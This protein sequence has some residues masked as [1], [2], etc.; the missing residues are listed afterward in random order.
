MNKVFI[1]CE[2]GVTNYGNLELAKKQIDA[3]VEAGADA[4]KF[5]AWKTE[6]LVSKKVAARLENELGYNWFDRLKYK[7]LS[8]DILRELQQYAQ[9]KE[10]EFFATPHDNESLDFVAR[11]LNVP[12]IKIGSGEA[13]NYEFLKRAGSYSKPI[14]ISFGMHNDNEIKKAVETLKNSGAGDIAIFHCTTKYPTP[15][16]EIDLPRISHL[17]NITGLSVGFSDHSVG[18]HSVLA[19]VVAGAGF[20]EKHLT[21]DKSDPRSLDNPGALLPEEFKIMVAQI[22]DVEKSL[23]GISSE[24]KLKNL[25][26]SRKWAGQAI[27]ANRNIIAGE[28]IYE[29]MLAFKRPGKGGLPPDAVS[30]IIGKTTKVSIE[31]DE[32]IQLEHLL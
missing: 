20:V 2:A 17:K 15:F 5:Q 10:I 19:G 32:Q 21:F 11:D 30:K 9:K 3:A 27:V 8:F 28:V 13:H 7:E 12:Y 18:W 22:R 31:E 4:V 25:A 16:E 29:S 24:G 26:E 23:Q 14:F 1:I 6:N